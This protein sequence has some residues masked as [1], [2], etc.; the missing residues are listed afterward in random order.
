MR[1][2]KRWQAASATV[3]RPR[4]LHP[5]GARNRQ[6]RCPRGAREGSRRSES[7]RSPGSKG[8]TTFVTHRI[9]QVHFPGVGPVVGRHWFQAVP[10]IR[11]RRN[12][13]DS[14]LIR[15]RQ[16]R[17]PLHPSGTRLGRYQKTRGSK[18]WTGWTASR[19]ARRDP[20]CRPRRRSTTSPFRP[21]LALIQAGC[22]EG[23]SGPDL[24]RNKPASWRE[25]QS[26]RRTLAHLLDA[27]LTSPRPSAL[28]QRQ[29]WIPE[30][31]RRS[32]LPHT[33]LR[34]ASA[35]RPRPLRLPA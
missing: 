2:W 16:G 13:S 21:G 10:G 15:P 26:E 5:A 34:C 27:P 18:G 30:P 12:P 33:S 6:C 3:G 28:D 23:G 20:K 19:L 32:S 25:R 8:K 7:E 14:G 1:E 11:G 4:Q 24:H 29:Y 22:S 17:F 35:G 31:A 9:P